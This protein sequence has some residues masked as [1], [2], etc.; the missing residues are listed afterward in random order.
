MSALSQ[1]PSIQIQ[2]VPNLLPLESNHAQELKE[3]LKCC[4]VESKIKGNKIK[5]FKNEGFY[6][7][8]FVKSTDST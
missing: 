8:A 7:Y 1:P 4:Q 3:I 6:D 2:W 5:Q